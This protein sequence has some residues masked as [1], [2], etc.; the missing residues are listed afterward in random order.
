MCVAATNAHGIH[1][2]LEVLSKQKG[3][4]AAAKQNGKASAAATSAKPVAVNAGA[5]SSKAAAANAHANVTASPNRPKGG[6]KL[7]IA[8]TALPNRKKA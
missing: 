1:K 2:E 4:A 3:A 5:G 6:V 7:P 8:G